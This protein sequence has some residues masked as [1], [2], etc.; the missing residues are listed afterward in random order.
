ML[1]FLLLLFDHYSYYSYSDYSWYYFLNNRHPKEDGMASDMI[2]LALHSIHSR[3]RLLG[4]SAG[5]TCYMCK[6]G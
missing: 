6:P 1:S 2:V 4:F 3:F 5:I